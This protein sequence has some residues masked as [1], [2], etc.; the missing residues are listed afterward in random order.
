MKRDYSFDNMKVLL[1]TLVVF[2]H[3][4]EEF[5]TTGK[6]GLIRAV[7]YSFHMPLFI[8]ISGYFSKSDAKPEK[9]L[10]TTIIPFIIFNTIWMFIQGTAINKINFFK[11][12]YVFWYLLSLF[13]WRV[14]VKYFDRV[15]GIVI[16]A[17]FV[18]IYCGCIGEAERFFSISRTVSFFSY[19]ILGYK[20]KKESIEKIRKIPK[21][22]SLVLLIVAFAVTVYLNI[23]GIMPVKMY[24]LIQSYSATKLDNMQGMVLR[25]TIY[26]IATIIIFALVNLMPDKE[27]PVTIY[28]QRTLCIYV[29]SSF[30][31]I[32]IHRLI[33]NVGIT[34]EEMPLQIIVALGITA[35]TFIVTGNKY[36]NKGYNTLMEKISS[37]L[38]KAK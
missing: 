4:L 27:F 13:F 7:I 3:A 15:K 26:I 31:I 25:G 19:F 24:E 12:I 37:Y 20:F 9:L 2:G 5:G 1:I 11:P 6:L 8:F 22:Y 35:L 10:K 32:P 36:V 17:F 14:T 18:G 38:I 21:I 34:I 29:L 23:R 33:T 16:L 28:G 30:V